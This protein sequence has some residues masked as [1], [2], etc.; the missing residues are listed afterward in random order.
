MKLGA[1]TYLFNVL[2]EFGGGKFVILS[3]LTLGL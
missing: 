1:E 3:S 2:C